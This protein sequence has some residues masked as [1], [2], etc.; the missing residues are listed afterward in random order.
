M[1]N[2]LRGREGRRC[3]TRMNLNKDD[4]LSKLV[5]K[6]DPEVEVP[7][8]FRSS[9]W[10]QVAARE[11]KQRRSLIDALGGIFARPVYAGAAAVVA[12]FS[13]LGLAHLNAERVDAERRSEAAT[14]YLALISPLARVSSD[15]S[16]LNQSHGHE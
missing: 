11:E 14:S 2:I 1:Q 8:D 5:Q 6:W 9:V 16:T 4:D 15:G 3:R 7:R 10:A 13:S 12:L